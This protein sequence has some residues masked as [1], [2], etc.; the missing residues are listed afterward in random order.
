MLQL[1]SKQCQ[2]FSVS[3]DIESKNYEQNVK[4][5]ALWLQVSQ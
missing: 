4:K 3:G 2:M 5:P 1:A